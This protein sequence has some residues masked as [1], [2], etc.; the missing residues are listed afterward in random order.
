MTC[1]RQMI[2]IYRTRLIGMLS[3]VHM[4]FF[5]NVWTFFC[6]LFIIVECF[7]FIIV[8]ARRD[9]RVVEGGSLENYCGATHR[10]FESLSLRCCLHYDFCA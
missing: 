10:G 9:G 4:F 5:S 8:S 1:Q 6:Q 2:A 3:H 7:R